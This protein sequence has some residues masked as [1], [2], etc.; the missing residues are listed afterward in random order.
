MVTLM[1]PTEHDAPDYR[2]LSSDEK[3]TTT[4]SGATFIEIDTGN[5]YVF[6]A[7]NCRWDKV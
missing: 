6:D 1:N 3:P 5:L 2:G 4:V 7:T